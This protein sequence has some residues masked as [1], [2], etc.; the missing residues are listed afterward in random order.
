[1]TRTTQLLL[2]L[3]AA[4]A[5]LL[6]SAHAKPMPAAARAPAPRASVAKSDGSGDHRPYD[7]VFP[8]AL[9]PEGKPSGTCKPFEVPAPHKNLL[10]YCKAMRQKP[11][12]YFDDLFSKSVPKKGDAFPLTGCVFGCL[13]SK[14]QNIDFQEW[15]STTFGWSGKCFSEERKDG[16]PVRFGSTLQ[17]DF[18]QMYNKT[19][20]ERAATFKGAGE[21]VFGGDG[22]FTEKGLYDQKPAWQYKDDRPSQ[23]MAAAG[24]WRSLYFMF[25]AVG[26][27][28]T[29]EFRSIG[30]GVLLGKTF[31]AGPQGLIPDRF[32]VERDTNFFMLFQ[33]CT[34]DGKIAWKPEQRDVPIVGAR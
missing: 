18:H 33:A 15:W 13:V 2:L 34:A 32:R 12:E 29:D 17:R 16:V 31:Y 8:R 1:M 24:G 5:A 30:P 23:Q 22:W 10:S 20:A 25:Q 27:G 26:D 21:F 28:V 11:K 3:G 9:D 6:A 19:Q 4:T 7:P 14:G